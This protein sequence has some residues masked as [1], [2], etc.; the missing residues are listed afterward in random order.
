MQLFVKNNIVFA[1]HTNDQ[2][3]AHLYPDTKK[4]WCDNIKIYPNDSL[5]ELDLNVLKDMQRKYLEEQF[6]LIRDLGCLCSNNIKLQCAEKDISR[7]GQAKDLIDLTSLTE[8]EVRDFDNNNRVVSVE[9]FNT[10]MIEVVVYMQS[11]L[12]SLWE[13]KDLVTSATTQQDV[14]SVEMT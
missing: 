10:M 3:V 11:L 8:I 9:V 13:K 12:S 7:W 4:Y 14:L 2:E 1:I 6:D 5:L